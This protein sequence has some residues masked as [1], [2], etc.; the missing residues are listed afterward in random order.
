MVA[1]WELHLTDDTSPRPDPPTPAPD[2]PDLFSSVDVNKA[3]LSVEDKTPGRDGLRVSLLKLIGE[4][5]ADLLATGFNNASRNLID[6]PSKTSHTIFLQ[7]RGGSA[8]NPADYR[9][10]ALQPVMTKLAEKLIEH[11]IWDQ[12]DKQQVE[13]SDDQG[14]FRPQRSRFDLIFL[15]RC[16]QDHYYPRGRR[17]TK[18]HYKTL[19]A[20]FLDIAKAYDSV[21]H[22]KIV[23]G[24]RHLGVR[25]DLI[26]MVTDLLSNRYTTIFGR[27]IHVTK[28]V[29]QGSPL[30]PLLFILAMM[31]PLSARMAQHP[32]GGAS[33]PGGLLFKEGFYADDIVLV[34]E[35]IAELQRML[36]I[37]ESW[38]N[39]VGLKFNVPKSKVMVLAG[40]RRSSLM[41]TLPNKS[42]SGQTT[43]RTWATPSTPT[44][45]PRTRCPLTFDFSTLCCNL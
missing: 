35:S 28:G 39:S 21:P 2:Q 42:F 27:R 13:L 37:C 20:A 41:S 32:G 45:R 38:A 1:F 15:I 29:P 33:L 19:Y 17:R 43:S 5:T 4:G 10:I 36:A 7:K 6:T 44:T 14:G 34:A 12:I 26:R 11:Q 16:L 24:L 9:P 22:V 3:I 25:E 30:S 23:E 40:P 8:T 31:Q 18:A